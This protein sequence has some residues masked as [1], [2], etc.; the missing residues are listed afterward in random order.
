MALAN[1]S[2][3]AVWLLAASVLGLAASLGYYFAPE[4]GID[5][6]LG[7]ALVIGS[8]ALMLIA[9]AAIAFGYAR[10]WIKGLLAALI[11][12]DIIGTGLAAYMLE[13]NVLIA[14]MALALIA[15]LYAVL[16][17]PPRRP[18]ADAQVVS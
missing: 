17:G 16:A 9:A 12:L 6:S 11:L 8:T 13:A 10:G 2:R 7:A 14:S 3:R 18:L 4:D 1:A 15:W 5:G